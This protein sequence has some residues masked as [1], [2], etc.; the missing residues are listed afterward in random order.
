MRGQRLM[1]CRVPSP[2][3]QP[4]PASRLSQFR[5]A[6][7]V[8]D[9][10]LVLWAAG[11]ARLVSLERHAEPLNL[12]FN[13]DFLTPFG[14]FALAGVLFVAVTESNRSLDMDG[15][16][17]RKL[18]LWGP[19]YLLA[20]ILAGLANWIRTVRLKARMSAGTPWHKLPAL[21]PLW[22]G[23]YVP[24]FVRRAAAVPYALLGDALLPRLVSALHEN[25]R[26]ASSEWVMELT[27]PVLSTVC[28]YLF[29]VVGP[30][31]ATGSTVNPLVWA[32]RFASY[33]VAL[34]LGQPTGGE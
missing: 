23:P 13:G 18:L 28:V 16:L 32:S 17:L 10:L 9:L 31:V 8:E 20:S 1:L 29:A 19:L 21:D 4:S 26:T 6:V 30:R 12:F 27:I 14:W 24:R 34:A 3:S 2:A 11:L 22:P 33:F 25:V 7:E 15:M 5:G